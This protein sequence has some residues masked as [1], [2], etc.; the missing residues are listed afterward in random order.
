MIVATCS[1]Q[2]K[3][4]FSL[5]FPTRTRA[6]S[7]FLFLP[8]PLHLLGVKSWARVSCVWRLHPFSFTCFFAMEVVQS[9]EFQIVAVKVKVNA[10]F[11]FTL[12]RLIYSLLWANVKGE[13]KKGKFAECACAYIR[14]GACPA[15]R[16]EWEFVRGREVLRETREEVAKSG[17]VL[18]ESRLVFFEWSGGGREKR[19]LSSFL[20]LQ[21]SY[22]GRIAS[23]N[24][25]SNWF[26]RRKMRFRARI[27]RELK[28]KTPRKR[29]FLPQK[30]P[31][32]TKKGGFGGEIIGRDRAK[33]WTLLLFLPCY[34]VAK[35]AQMNFSRIFF[36]RSL[37]GN[38]EMPYL[39]TRNREAT[40]LQERVTLWRQRGSK[41]AAVIFE[42]LT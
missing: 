39:C 26:F 16:I 28:R 22:L 33:K 42:S 29:W 2:R 17:E 15:R 34:Q 1:V 35:W 41:S 31:N 7:V 21:K 9:V 23:K 4:A 10:G 30:W 40:L 12:N 14:V 3:S 24:T 27:S 13:G 25:S 32:R 38:A 20:R 11:A 5:L 36:R 19:L 18:R 8:S 37:A 6:S